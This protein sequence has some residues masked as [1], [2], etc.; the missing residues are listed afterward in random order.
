MVS[1]PCNSLSY[2]FKM[3]APKIPVK[4]IT[5]LSSLDQMRAISLIHNSLK[6]K[7]RQIKN[8]FV[9]G[10]HSNTMFLDVQNAKYNDKFLNEIFSSEELN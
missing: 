8:I 3:F 1:N 4:E 10:N 5:F 2:I 7:T 6:L 9:I